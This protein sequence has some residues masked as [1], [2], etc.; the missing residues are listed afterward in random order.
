M[1]I[2]TL[3]RLTAAH[4]T[5]AV[6]VTLT[7]RR[8]TPTPHASTSEAP[9]STDAAIIILS[10][11]AITGT[12]ISVIIGGRIQATA[13]IIVA[14]TM[15]V[16]MLVIIAIIMHFDRAE[17]VKSDRCNSCGGTHNVDHLLM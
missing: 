15:M 4:T 1:D 14:I 8:H 11:T 3:L 2:A 10:H 17:Q 5:P 13:V 16:T 12:T 9:I 7:T 6:S